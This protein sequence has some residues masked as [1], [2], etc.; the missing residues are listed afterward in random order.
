MLLMKHYYQWLK[1]DVFYSTIKRIGQKSPC[2][3]E[4]PLPLPCCLQRAVRN[5]EMT[6]T[7]RNLHHSSCGFEAR[8]IAMVP[9]VPQQSLARGSEGQGFSAGCNLV[10][11]EEQRAAPSLGQPSQHTAHPPQLEDIVLFQMRSMLY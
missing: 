8:D 6:S 3:R 1:V 4:G 11:K 2:T 7:A 10:H 9:K 5:G